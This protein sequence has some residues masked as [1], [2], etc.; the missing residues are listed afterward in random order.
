MKWVN[1]ESGLE[2]S[3]LPADLCAI[4]GCEKCPGF[5]R[6]RDLP[7]GRMREIGPV[8]D[9]PTI[10]VACVHECHQMP[11]EELGAKGPVLMVV[12]PRCG[13]V[14]A[15]PGFAAEQYFCHTCGLH[16][17]VGEGPVQ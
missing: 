4:Y 9:D 17:K 14:Q 1:F 16:V 11:P 8:P 5:A 6:V 13:A 10:L 7:E 3:A 2:E 12:C 15:R